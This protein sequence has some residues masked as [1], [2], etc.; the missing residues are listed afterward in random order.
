MGTN[1][2]LKKLLEEGKLPPLPR[3]AS[4]APPKKCYPLEPPSGH[5][6]LYEMVA[7]R[8]Q[9]LEWTNKQLLAAQDALEK[10]VRELSAENLSLRLLGIHGLIYRLGSLI[11]EEMT[12]EYPNA[13]RIRRWSAEAARLRIS[14]K[15]LKESK[16]KGGKG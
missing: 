4:P 16:L 9:A 11:N 7:H 13:G 10:E 3:K 15:T 2:K 1:W 5:D 6:H 12:K 8:I 14:Y